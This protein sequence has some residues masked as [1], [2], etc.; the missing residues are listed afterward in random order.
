MKNKIFS[1]AMILMLTASLAIAQRPGGQR[2]AFGVWE[3]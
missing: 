2:T 3:V 1:I